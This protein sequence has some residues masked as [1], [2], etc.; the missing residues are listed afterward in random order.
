MLDDTGADER[1]GGEELSCPMATIIND[2][3][4]ENEGIFSE[5]QTRRRLFCVGGESNGGSLGS[6]QRMKR[7]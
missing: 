1:L 6:V 5:Y 3:R 7:T 4:V 2:G